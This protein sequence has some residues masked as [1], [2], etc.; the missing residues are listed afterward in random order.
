MSSNS[1]IAMTT[2]KESYA[3]QCCTTCEGFYKAEIPGMRLQ[4]IFQR[5][6]AD[7]DYAREVEQALDADLGI[8]DGA[9]QYGRDG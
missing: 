3:V 6:H 5:K 4:T 2:R 7:L 9:S 1:T 8:T